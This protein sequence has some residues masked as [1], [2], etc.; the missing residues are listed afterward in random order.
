MENTG[1]LCHNC[2]RKD[3]SQQNIS[4]K[5][6]KFKNKELE[7]KFTCFYNRLAEASQEESS[8]GP[9]PIIVSTESTAGDNKLDLSTQSRDTAETSI[10]DSI[11]SQGLDNKFIYLFGTWY[12][13]TITNSSGDSSMSCSR[14]DSS[15]TST[16]TS[17]I[18]RS[19]FS[20]DSSSKPTTSSSSSSGAGP[21]DNESQQLLTQPS[22]EIE[23]QTPSTDKSFEDFDGL[24]Q[25]RSPSSQSTKTAIHYSRET[26]KDPNR[27]DI[28]PDN[29]TKT[30][31][32]TD[33]SSTDKNKHKTRK[34]S[35][36]NSL[37]KLSIKNLPSLLRSLSSQTNIKENKKR[38]KI[39]ERKSGSQY[40]SADNMTH[41]VSNSCEAINHQMSDTILNKRRSTA[42]ELY[43]INRFDCNDCED[44][45]CNEERVELM[46]DKTFS[47]NSGRDRDKESTVSKENEPKVSESSSIATNE[48]MPLIGAPNVQK[49]PNDCH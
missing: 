38:L 22:I 7:E 16:Y 30:H 5:N 37:K 47:D 2:S 13:S 4:P 20:S 46:S 15:S 31:S 36:E 43:E 32:M 11:V 27:L 42:F 26:I 39:N 44:I 8:D 49:P 35:S 1:Y 25:S 48:D 17:R 18:S 29:I 34:V 12:L 10:Q 9:E 41:L 6:I 40:R 45:V 23:A 14:Q 28:S 33:F 24:C 3:S 19:S 21:S